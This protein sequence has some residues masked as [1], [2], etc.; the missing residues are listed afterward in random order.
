MVWNTS[1]EILELCLCG[2]SVSIDTEFEFGGNVKPGGF[3]SPMPNYGGWEIIRSLDEG[4]QGQVSLV[5][6]PTRAAAREQTRNLI[7]SLVRKTGTAAREFEGGIA[8]GLEESFGQK[9]LEAVAEYNRPDAPDELGALKQLKLPPEGKE[10][11]WERFKNE[12]NA[13]KMMEGDPAVLR[14][15]QFDL[16]EHWMITDYHPGGS[17][18]KHPEMFKGNLLAAL[19][20]LRPIIAALAKLHAKGIVHRD[21]KPQ[22]IFLS[23]TNQLVLGDFGIVF[24][25]T[26]HRATELLER[27]GSRDWMAPWGHI[28][29]RVDDVKPNFDIFPLG[30]VIWSMV[31]GRPMLPYWYHFRREYNLTVIFPN[32]PTMHAA[33]RI[34]DQCIVENESDCL[35]SAGALLPIVDEFLKMLANGG[36][37]LSEGVPRP[38]RVCGIGQYQP[39]DDRLPSAADTQVS[40]S[41]QQ[42]YLALQPAFHAYACNYCNHIQFFG[43][44][45]PQRVEEIPPPAPGRQ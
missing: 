42:R 26:G 45:K 7:P 31:A 4:G 39:V 17:L 3:F 40:E 35:S 12:I 38:C 28:G 34:L 30:K 14:V 1:V 36:Q 24:F 44:S 27:V 29:L 41:I 21:I 9:L 16:N 5:R 32:D 25:E 10:P 22:N 19:R 13:L 6:S 43:R 33:N 18:S 11:T 23:R 20:A 8:P 37:L 2:D 15:L